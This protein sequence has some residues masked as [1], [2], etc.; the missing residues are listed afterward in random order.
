MYGAD[1]GGTY[2]T[3]SS[4]VAQHPP[5]SVLSPNEQNPAY[6]PPSL[7]GQ[8]V[9][10]YTPANTNPMPGVYVPP[11]PDTPAWQQASHAPLQGGK[12]KYTKPAPD[13]HSY[14]QGGS[15]MY[16]QGQYGQQPGQQA[17][18]HGQDQYPPTGQAPPPAQYGQPAQNSYP[19]GQSQQQGLYGDNTQQ[20]P[21]QQG[22]PNQQQQFTGQP[23]PPY[24]H[25]QDQHSQSQPYQQQSQNQWQP[26][27]PAAQ[28]FSQHQA[29]AESSYGG[30]QHTWQPTHQTQGSESTQGIQAPTP[31]NGHTGTTPPGFV[32][33]PS[34]QSQPV[35]PIQNRFSTG[36]SGPARTGS[37]SSIALGAIHAQRAGNR[38]ESPKPVPPP[39]HQATKFSALGTGGPS[40]WEHFGGAEEVDDEELFAPKKD[41]RQGVPVQLDSVEVPPQVSPPQTESEWPTPP[42]QPIT[43]NIPNRDTY[44]PTPPPNLS[45]QR[46]P[47]QPPQ[48]G[49]SRADV[50]PA[51][52]TM[53]TQQ[54]F[55]MDDAMVAPLRISRPSSQR[56]TPAQQQARHQP[57]PQAEGSFNNNNFAPAAPLIDP[58]A[59]AALAAELKEKGESLERLRTDFE[60][61]KAKLHAEVEQLKV[62]IE[63]TK[64][65]AEY[66]RNVLTEQIN[67]MKST[68]E[69]TKTNSDAL[70]KEKDSTI[71]R[72]KEDG[73]GKAD[74]I[75]EKDAEIARLREEA[76]AK[77]DTIS[78]GHDFVDNLKRQVEVKDGEI[79]NLKQQIENNQTAER[80]ATDL[81]QQLEAEKSK[82]VPKP[83]PAMLVSDLDSWYA[84]S[85][86]RY[87]A[88]LRSEAHE[89]V[90]E[91]KIKVFTSFLKAESSAR[92]IDYYSAPPPQENQQQNNGQPLPSTQRDLTTSSNDN[93][94]KVKVPAAEPF[95]EDDIQYSPGGRPIV[96]H[97]PTLKPEESV[98][99]QQ[100][101]NAPSNATG[102]LTPTSSQDDGF[103][104]TPT[105]VQS[106][107]VEQSHYKAYVPASVTQSD[108]GQTVHR[109]SVSSA[110]PPALNPTL[111][112]GNKKDEVFFGTSPATRS[113]TSRPNTG[114]GTP[115]EAF[116]PA[117]LSTQRPLALATRA[118]PKGNPAER[119]TSL[120]PAKVGVPVPNPQLEKVRNTLSS[121]L[122]EIPSLVDL[123]TPWDKS[124]SVIRR[125]NDAARRKRQEESEEH[126]DQLFNDHEISYADI[127]VIEDEFKEKELKLKSDE[128]RDEY[129]SYV[130]AVFDKVYNGL[131]Q[132]IKEL[133][134]LYIEVESILPT[135]VSGRKSFEGSD[136]AITEN[137]LKLMEDLFEAIEQRHEKVVESVAERDKRYKKTEIQPLYAAGNITKMKQVEKHFANAEKDAALH[138]RDEKA[139]R[140][141]D[142]VHMVEETVIAAVGVE[143]QEIQD[144]IEA[145][146][147]LPPSPDNEKLLTRAKETVLALSDSSKALLQLLND[148]E[149]DVGGSVLEAQLAAA[150]AEK[151]AD[152]VAALE[153]QIADREAALKDEFKRKESVLDQDRSVIEEVI[154]AKANQPAEGG[155]VALSE[156]ELKK[157]RLSKAL[158]EAKRRNGDL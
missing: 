58:Q 60:N 125:K 132:Q 130:E 23:A 24:Q 17:P 105:P 63:T 102:I 151:Q 83:T 109:Q 61:E 89:A 35:S 44:Q 13:P 142:F 146:R 86:E 153:K 91:D 119:L 85:L 70:V 111:S 96:Q 77:E 33:E 28:G 53:Q 34:P 25:S 66:E 92:G 88:M 27:P 10:S 22:L 4:A 59:H 20:Q 144:I 129:K 82:E 116:V 158:E 128:D 138:A 135:A 121:A 1:Q 137:C 143:Q 155:G 90:V 122:A 50:P 107:P 38:T 39:S 104:K 57:P 157:E 131:Q 73:E 15:S 120:L 115:P 80:L 147:D 136:A 123:T 40:D 95:D 21:A 99:T 56:N 19:Q 51:A 65:H 75:K 140:V 31:V 67:T 108:F 74:T 42:V 145:T 101:F 149:I 54:G 8:G 100:T 148:V 139:A 79:S 84:G 98:R 32:Q 45:S 112:Y 9:Q 118:P 156:E 114:D 26:T 12:F 113:L 103:N 48:Q 152:K 127:A 69:Q 16:G 14:T 68:A 62:V 46:P 72:L 5:N 7:T 154:V 141:D 94:I 134:D 64:T 30:Q 78:K 97:R 93:D 18:Q 87:I 36:L 29:N 110:T 43:T 150:K 71:E 126:T 3:P 37:V 76:K 106:P 124:A 49:A 117:P 6:V 55:V 41:G 11:P 47:M 81:R 52:H 133:M 2:S